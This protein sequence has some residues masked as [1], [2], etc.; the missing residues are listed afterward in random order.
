M[1]VFVSGGS[2]TE[3]EKAALK[4]VLEEINGVLEKTHG[5]TLRLVGWPDT[6]R[7]G[8]NA[9]PQSE[10]NRQLDSNYDVYIGLLGSWFG[11]PTPRAGSGTEEEFQ[12]ALSLFQR[13]TRSIRLLFYFKRAAQDPFAVDLQQLQSVREFRD[14][15]P[16]RGVLY[17]DFKDTP[18]FIQIVR[19]N[20][21]HLI[22]DEWHE[23][24][25]TELPPGDLTRPTAP[26]R[27]AMAGD[28]ATSAATSHDAAVVCPDPSLAEA[29]PRAKSDVSREE[30]IDEE[31]GLLEV[32][33]ELQRAVA[34]LTDTVAR[35][36]EHTVRIG[37]QF[38]DR[39]EETSR[40]TEQQAQ[41]E[42]IGGSRAKQEYLA[43]A[44]ELVNQAAVDLEQYADDMNADLLGFRADIRAMLLSM[45]RAIALQRE[46]EA[47]PD[48]LND[49][50]T[51]LRTLVETMTTSR[52]E[53][54]VFQASVAR[55]PPLTGRFKRARKKATAMLGELI[56]E[57][58]F[59][60]EEGNT[61][62]VELDQLQSA[63]DSEP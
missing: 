44:R 35:I 48:Q 52:T 18:E 53:I 21:H 29:A 1:T 19:E 49:H 51:A 26:G 5:V 27:P 4:R 58:Q 2:E 11:T 42:H 41:L 20:L 31:L 16:G 13:D 23:G 47:S 12:R 43:K 39:T 61:I 56:A 6:I 46:F 28:S 30:E 34:S 50:R 25:W 57:I 8:V 55:M 15:L 33:E 37:A 63:R 10:I 14:S 17:R 36:G 7:P 54:T 40:L 38:R 3:A 32:M 24:S 9:D 62:L 60:I 59:S 45:R 22:I